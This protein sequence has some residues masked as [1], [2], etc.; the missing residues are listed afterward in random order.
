MPA[1]QKRAAARAPSG[2]AY[3]VEVVLARHRRRDVGHHSLRA[4]PVDPRGSELASNRTAFWFENAE[5]A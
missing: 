3:G 1:L 2:F 4:T 5:A